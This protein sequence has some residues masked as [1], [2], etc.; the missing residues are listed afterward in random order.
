VNRRQVL[1]ATVGS[2]LLRFYP[3]WG[4]RPPREESNEESNFVYLTWLRTDPSGLGLD[5]LE[6]AAAGSFLIPPH[7][8]REILPLMAE[9][10]RA[11]RAV[12]LQLLQQR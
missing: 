3:A 8:L 5:V 10:N 4:G 6:P 2:A 7:L 9:E 1:A 12:F 11:R